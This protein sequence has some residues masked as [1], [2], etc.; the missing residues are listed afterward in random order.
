MGSDKGSADSGID[1]F[2]RTLGV[3]VVG[4]AV[5]AVLMVSIH[6][7]QTHVELQPGNILLLLL[8]GAV[9][10]GIFSIGGFLIPW[11]KRGRGLT[12]L[13]YDVLY[14]LASVYMTVALVLL[15]TAL[16]LTVSGGSL[17]IKGNGGAMTF[18]YMRDLVNALSPDYLLQ[19]GLIPLIGGPL[20]SLLDLARA[21]IWRHLRPRAKPAQKNLE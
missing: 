9:V 15:L 18:L 8:A 12:T 3:N 21:E 4:G 10:G 5:W 16:V 17:P 20:V 7:I 13:L 11:V 19:L 14:G 1:V 2:L 6:R